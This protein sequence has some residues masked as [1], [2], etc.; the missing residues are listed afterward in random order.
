MNNSA[1][2]YAMEVDKRI[3]GLSNEEFHLK[4]A[5]GKVL[6]EELYPLSRLALFFKQ[7]GLEV[8]VEGFE[9]CGRADGKIIVTGFKSLEAE[10]QLTFAGY[11][12]DDA[13]RS[14]LLLSQGCAPFSGE[15]KRKKGKIE[16]RMEAVDPDE[17]IDK[18]AKSIVSRFQ[19]KSKKD[20][21]N[22]TIL[23]I[24]FDEYK[25]FGN[26]K[27]NLLFSKL[28]AEITTDKTLFS[29]VYL[30]NCWTNQL[31]LFAGAP[32]YNATVL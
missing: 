21:L 24:A 6:L 11:S 3:D 32:I 23:L 13:L 28:T 31:R 9:D 30:F 5:Q 10:I 20:Y 12:Y 16:A 25:L 17:Y 18:L 14:E 7:P 8:L 22:D 4:K 27:W 26:S 19:K 15:I 29:A 2:E 1:F